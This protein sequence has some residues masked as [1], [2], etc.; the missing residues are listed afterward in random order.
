MKEHIRCDGL[1]PTQSINPPKEHKGFSRKWMD[2]CWRI[3]LHQMLWKHDEEEG[4]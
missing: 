4:T 2:G 1:L 3:A